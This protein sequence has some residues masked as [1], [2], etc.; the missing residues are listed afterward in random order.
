MGIIVK[1]LTKDYGHHK[2]IFNLNFEVRQGEILG[3]L[4]PNGAGKT[5]TI[6]TLMG[7]IKADCG[8]AIIHDMDCFNDASK[9]QNYVGYLPGEI[10]FMEDMT[11]MEFISFMAKMKNMKDLSTAQELIH[12]FDLD[13]SHKIKKMSKG[14]KQK[15]GLVVAC[16]QDTPIL[17]L[18]EPTSGLDPLMQQKFIE[19]MK[20]YKKQGK[21]ILMS[22]HIF[23]EVENICD[24]VAFIK[25]GH[26]VAI[27]DMQ[28][29]KQQR[30][31]HYHILF[32]YE[33]EARDFHKK[34]PQSKIDNCIVSYIVQGQVNHFIQELSKYTINDLTMKQ[35]SLEDV[36]LQY[37]GG[38]E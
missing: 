1:N 21:T 10:A 23:E 13:P 8:E 31:R 37:Y 6:R 24:R 15:I 2:G 17:I 22:S 3:Y 4:G 34:H 35:Q 25:E 14:M 36:F 29:L 26:L 38:N 7:F 33:K 11:G 20:S 19:L 30:I 12:F 9:V 18:D 28:D 5:T 32:K 16:M 27:K